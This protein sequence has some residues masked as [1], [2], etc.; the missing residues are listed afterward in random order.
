MKI[1]IPKEALTQIMTEYNCSEDDA[2]K[3]YLDAHDKANEACRAFW[4]RAL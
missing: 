4:G 1:T 2:A 3:A